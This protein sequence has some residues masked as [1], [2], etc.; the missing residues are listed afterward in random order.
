M[1]FR[2]VADTSLTPESFIYNNPVLVIAQC[3]PKP[4]KR[5][6]PLWNWNRPFNAFKRSFKKP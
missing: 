5:W 6:P 3:I 1:R 2:P 4:M